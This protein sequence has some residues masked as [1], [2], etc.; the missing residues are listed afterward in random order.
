MPITL[1]T[2]TETNRYLPLLLTLASLGGGGGEGL[3]ERLGKEV[4]C[5]KGEEEKR[6]KNLKIE[7]QPMLLT[8]VSSSAF[9]EVC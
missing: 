3:E 6:R 1:S 4:K 8:R 5:R 2:L 7:N 9:I